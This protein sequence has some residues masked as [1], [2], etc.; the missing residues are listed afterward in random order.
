[1][2]DLMTESVTASPTGKLRRFVFPEL[3]QEA[4]PRRTLLRGALGS[5]TGADTFCWDTVFALR[6]SDMNTALQAPGACPASFT[7]AESGTWTGQGNFAPWQV[8]TGGGNPNM[9]VAI[10]TGSMTYSGITYDLSKSRSS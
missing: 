3:L 7:Q 2:S 10:T 1:M 9:T 8:T 5:G 4:P 6:A